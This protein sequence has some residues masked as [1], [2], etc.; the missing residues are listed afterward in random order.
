MISFPEITLE[1][2]GDR[3]LGA[4]LELICKKIDAEVKIPTAEDKG[5]WKPNVFIL[6]CG[7]P[8]D[9]I[10]KG[11]YELR[12]K[13]VEIVCCAAG[14]DAPIGLLNQISDNVVQLSSTSQ[15]DIA[16]FFEFQSQTIKA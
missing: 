14:F 10:I 1:T 3:A 7:S 4:A 16:S 6:I 9:N 15:S 8:T 13:S 12:N 11:A 2:G 5:D